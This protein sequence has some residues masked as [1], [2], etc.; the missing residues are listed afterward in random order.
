MDREAL[1][2]VLLGLLKRIAAGEWTNAK[3]LYHGVPC[4]W[5]SVKLL[6]GISTGLAGGDSPEFVLFCEGPGH[7]A[8]EREFIAH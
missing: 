2:R 4:G 7:D 6:E 5:L 3:W 1:L 8:D